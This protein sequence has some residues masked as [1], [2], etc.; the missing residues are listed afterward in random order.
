M[1][2]PTP[3]CDRDFA[4][5]IEGNRPAALETAEVFCERNTQDTG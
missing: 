4:Q 1:A 5:R 2:K 3:V